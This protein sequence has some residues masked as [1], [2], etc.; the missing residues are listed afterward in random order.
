MSAAFISL[1]LAKLVFQVLGVNI[2]GKLFLTKHLRRDTVLAFFDN[3][4][5]CVV[6]LEAR[7]EAYFRGREIARP[8][9]TVR[10][11]VLHFRRGP[12]LQFQSGAICSHPYSS[13]AEKIGY[14]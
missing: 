3:L 5:P 10:L 13:A 11:M 12:F 7:S 1:G 4:A 8:G 9:H 2:H 6:G 14:S